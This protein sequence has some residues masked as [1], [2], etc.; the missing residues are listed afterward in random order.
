MTVFYRE[1]L[2]LTITT[3]KARLFT[4]H[5]MNEQLL[6][7]R[8]CHRHLKKSVFLK[9]SPLHILKVEPTRF[10]DKLYMK[11]KRNEGWSQILGKERWSVSKSPWRGCSC[12]GQ[13]H[14]LPWLS[15]NLP[16]KSITRNSP[17]LVTRG[18]KEGEMEVPV[19]GPSGRRPDHGLVSGDQEFRWSRN[20][21]KEIPRKRS[22]PTSSILTNIVTDPGH[23]T[24]Q[25][26]GLD[27]V[28]MAY[29]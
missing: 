19:Q 29:K 4:Q 25:I 9:V 20:S 7:T 22:L 8:H 18:E 27:K 1:N 6:Y 24:I 23:R 17:V 21:E 3:W 16:S 28:H 13:C 5:I 10:P 26:W 15:P 14:G 2:L 11:R 12:F